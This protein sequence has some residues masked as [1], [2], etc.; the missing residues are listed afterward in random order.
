METKNSKKEKS[1]NLIT[2]HETKIVN[3]DR[4]RVTKIFN[5]NSGEKSYKFKLIYD[6]RNGGSDLDLYI[7]NSDGEFKFALNKEDIGHTFTVSYVS[8]PIGKE[9]D[10][11]EALKLV[12]K[13][14]P[15][16]YS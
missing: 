2:L 16:I 15:K 8:D 1:F 10:I 14:I 4:A 12:E 5:F 7:M 9:H 6:L 11:K 3:R 13:I